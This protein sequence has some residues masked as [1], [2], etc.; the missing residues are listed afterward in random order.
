[1]EMFCNEK[2]CDCRR[3]FFFVK[4]SHSDDVEAVVAWGWEASAFYSRWLGE[5][6]PDQVAL[7]KGPVLNMG[8]PQ[9]QLA[10]AILKV[11][12][13]VLLND[14]DFIERVKSHYRRFRYKVE[15]AAV[16][17]A[18]EKAKRKRRPR[19]KKGRRR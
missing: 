12:E 18:R 2:R 1:M 16:V 13:T 14:D 11:T 17:K 5:E 19:P 8:S 4:S 7:L 15:G 9:T 10:P 3:V 6:D